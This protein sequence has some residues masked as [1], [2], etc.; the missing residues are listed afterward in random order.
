MGTTPAQDPAPRPPLLHRLTPRQLVAVDL[1]LAGLL[2]LVAGAHAAAPSGGYRA[3]GDLRP[4]LV[5]AVAALAVALR[6][7]RP[8][9]S[10]ALMTASI[11]I[12]LGLP[13]VA[14]PDALIAF[15]AY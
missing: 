9:G 15:P 3:G 2:L 11:G 12:A 1:A 4:S 10:L 14:V 5:W 8:V 13:P 6:R 7:A